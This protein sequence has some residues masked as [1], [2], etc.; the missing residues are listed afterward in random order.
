MSEQRIVKTIGIDLPQ[1]VVDEA[2]NLQMELESYYHALVSSYGE[3]KE[4][5]RKD[6]MKPGNK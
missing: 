6:G 3:Q 2:R 1:R 5:Y 4:E